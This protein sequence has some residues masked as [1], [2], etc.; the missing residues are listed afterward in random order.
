MPVGTHADERDVEGTLTHH[1]GPR[2]SEGSTGLVEGTA[3][4]CP[5]IGGRHAH[6]LHACGRVKEALPY[7]VVVSL[8]VSSGHVALIN[9]PHA[10]ARPIDLA[11]A[12]KQRRKQRGRYR[13][14]GESKVDTCG[15]LRLA[16]EHAQARE[17]SLTDRLVQCIDCRAD[18]ER[19]NGEHVS[20]PSALYSARRGSSVVSSSP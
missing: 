9:H 11:D 14:T 18:L 1:V 7:L 2:G 5:A 13:A 6:E 17:E 19:V 15:C 4:R 16:D 3:A 8:L 12:G 10:H 20:Q